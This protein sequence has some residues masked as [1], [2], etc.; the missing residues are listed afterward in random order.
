MN[1]PGWDGGR[2]SLVVP[3]GEEKLLVLDKQLL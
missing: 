2:V 3:R 1:V